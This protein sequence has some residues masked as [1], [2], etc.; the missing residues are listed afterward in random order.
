MQMKF[1]QFTVV[2]ASLSMLVTGVWMRIDP[3]SFAEWANWPNHVHFLH[4]A[5]VFQIGIAMTMLFALWWRDVIAVV[6]AGFLVANSLHAVNHFL[7]RDG[8]N[9]SDWWQLGVFSLLAATALTVRLRQ[10]QLK[11]IDPVSR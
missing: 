9:P 4:D 3:A 11:T 1:I 8:G 2:V 5:G 6:L 7:D 10:L